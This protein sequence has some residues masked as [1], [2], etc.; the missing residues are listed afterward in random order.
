[1][2][3]LAAA[4]AIAASWVAG[5]AGRASA[6]PNPAF[7]YRAADDVKEV[8]A[9][10]WTASTEIGVVLTTGNSETTT[11]TASGKLGRRA[12]KNKLELTGS[13]AYARASIRS[14][15][16]RDGN[17]T[18][19]PGEIIGTT[20]ITAETFEAK[21]RYDRYLD[22]HDSLYLS[23]MVRRDRPAGK[24][25]VAGGQL[26]YSRVLDKSDT[27]EATA[28]AGYD[29]SYENQVTPGPGIFIHSARAFLG[30]KGKASDDNAYEA[31]VEYLTNLS[32]EDAPAGQ[33]DRLDD[34]RIN[35]H[36]QWTSKVGADLSL[37]FTFDMH[38]DSAPAPLTLAGVTFDP[39]YLPESAKVD[40][41]FKGSI[42]YTFF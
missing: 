29:L 33:V 40:S 28:E 25:L 11:A 27:F 1:M 35:V 18:I 8:K 12:G 4:I 10:E 30:V 5:V 36:S 23:G 32:D 6:Q 21:A 9:V 3:K 24:Q 38:F 26:G 37:A 20:Q 14:A 34:N 39:G 7:T 31:S 16:D 17:G 19:G 13:L 2:A 42:I 15:V 41:L 22:D